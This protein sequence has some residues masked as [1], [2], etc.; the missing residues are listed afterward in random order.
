M[1]Y[2]HQ[3]FSIEMNLNIISIHTFYIGEKINTHA[4]L[5]LGGI[6]L[7]SDNM[8]P[9]KQNI[10]VRG[11]ED[12][13]LFFGVLDK[14][15]LKRDKDLLSFQLSAHSLS[16][17]MDW[18]KRKRVFQDLDMTYEQIIEEVL[19]SYRCS[20]FID[21]V[22]NGMKIPHSILQFNETDWEFLKRLASHY[23][24]GICVDCKG[25]SI[26]IF[27]GTGDKADAALE[28][29]ALIREMNLMKKKELIKLRTDAPANVGSQV[30]YKGKNY[31]IESTEILM[32]KGALVYQS[33]LI[34]TEDTLFPF[35]PNSNI[36]G[37]H[38]WSW[39]REIQRNQIRIQ[40]QIED[41]AQGNTPFLPFA[42]EENNEAGYYMPEPGNEVEVTFPDSEEEHAFVSAAR[43]AVKERKATK[44]S[45]KYLRN[46][47]GLGLYMDEQKISVSAG[48]ANSEL[49][50]SQN[51][52]I[53]IW[54]P[55]SISIKP[56]ADLEI[57][58]RGG[59][60]TLQ[61]G[62]SITLQSGI[63]GAS[64]ILFDTSGNIICKARQKV[65]IRGS[66]IIPKADGRQPAPSNT[67]KGAHEVRGATLALSGVEFLSQ[68]VTGVSDF[69]GARKL[70]NH[71]LGNG[72][73]EKSPE[74]SNGNLIKE[75][76]FQ[77]DERLFNSFSYGESKRG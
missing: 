60:V 17:D 5:L 25:S 53:Y 64:R 68:S 54:V 44:S 30:T 46:K 50:M 63:T 34:R 74:V 27:F 6:C 58:G 10:I 66:G 28:G 48:S 37:M 4:E 45:M 7:D 15:E 43:R 21:K 20:S 55:E 59:T 52:T 18:K 49:V 72:D 31:L 51:G 47:D 3:E 61:A 35:I 42:G 39:A 40:Y 70:M 13:V 29:E 62:N 24:T 2:Q 41:K 23:N 8:A 12:R 33:I 67:G 57:G 73:G 38:I 9:E 22:T 75:K 11:N 16:Y 56:G 77:N 71:L 19:Q 14:M 26:Q 65:V 1:I 32:E 69:Q 36:A 76:L